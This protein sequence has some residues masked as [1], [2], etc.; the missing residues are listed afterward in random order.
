M[1]TIRI[2]KK[3]DFDEPA[4][5]NDLLD[6]FI[7]TSCLQKNNG[8]P[9]P[10]SRSSLSSYIPYVSMVLTIFPNPMIWDWN[11]LNYCESLL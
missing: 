1:K 3:T 4:V 6:L 7:L 9:L 11:L 8:L 2:R 5:W 10:K